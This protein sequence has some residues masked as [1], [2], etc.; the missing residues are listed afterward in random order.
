M[1]SIPVVDAWSQPALGNFRQELPEVVRLFEKSGT[2]GLLDR[3]LS[4]ADIVA[5]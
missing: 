1:D 2:A 4:P 5:A 3:K